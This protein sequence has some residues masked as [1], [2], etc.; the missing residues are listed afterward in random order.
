MA[1]PSNPSFAL[2]PSHGPPDVEALASQASA[3]LALTA[4]SSQTFGEAA[5]RAERVVG[6]LG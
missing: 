6:G 3:E 4:V 5:W 1:P 2:I